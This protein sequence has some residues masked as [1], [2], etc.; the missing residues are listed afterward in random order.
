M[1]NSTAVVTIDNWS[2]KHTRV[3]ELYYL[4][5]AGPAEIESNTGFS[6][7]K[8]YRII[9]DPRAK[10]IAETARAKILEKTSEDIAERVGHKVNELRGKAADALDRTLSADINPLH[11]AKSNQ[12]RVA[13]KVLQGSGDLDSEREGDRGGIVMTP[14]MFDRLVTAFEKADRVSQMDV[15]TGKVIDVED[16]EIEDG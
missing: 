3:V 4:L 12:D 6:K 10:E 13:L 14:E 1:S 9:K 16:V 11:K 7:S 5:G 15:E 8:I 2:E